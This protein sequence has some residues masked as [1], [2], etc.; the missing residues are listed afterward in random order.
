MYFCLL[1]YNS[2]Q[3]TS[4]VYYYHNLISTYKW[5]FKE[6]YWS[7]WYINMLVQMSNFMG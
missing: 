7:Q 5:E 4:H 1:L 2:L 3:L 6:C